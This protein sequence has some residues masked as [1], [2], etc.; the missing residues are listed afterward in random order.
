MTLGMKASGDEI[1]GPFTRS[2]NLPAGGGRAVGF[3]TSIRAQRSLSVGYVPVEITLAAQAPLPADRRLVYRFTTIEGGQT[4]PQNGMEID[5]P[6]LAPQ[7]TRNAKW[8]RYLPK[9]SAGFALEVT[10]YEDGRAILDYNDVLGDGLQPGRQKLRSQLDLEYGVNW[11]YVSPDDTVVEDKVPNLR[12][13]WQDAYRGRAAGAPSFWSQMLRGPTVLGVGQS[14]LPTDWRGYQNYDAVIL[15]T[16]SAERLVEKEDEWRA[17]RGWILNGGALVIYDAVSPQESSSLLGFAWSDDEESANRIVRGVENYEKG[18]S[19]RRYQAQRYITELQTDLTNT[20]SPQP[21]ANGGE[22][23]ALLPNNQ[24]KIDLETELKRWQERRQSLANETSFSTAEWRRR[25]HLQRVGSGEV[26]FLRRTAEGQAPP[27]AYWSVVRYVLDFRVSPTVRRGVDPMVG[28]RKFSSWL[29]PGVAQPPVYTFMG[30]LTAFVILVGPIAYRRTAKQG[31]SYLMFAIAPVLA[32]LT[33]VAMFG[34]GI[35]SDGFGTVV[36]VRQLT[37]VDGG[38]K[39]AGER[40]RSTYFAGVRPGNGLTFASDAEVVG[41]REGTGQAWE[42]LDEL[43]YA[44]MGRITIREDGQQFD[45]SFLPSRQQKQ[46]IT[47]RP[48]QDLGRVRLIPDRKGISS[49]RVKNEFPFVLRSLV[50]RDPKGAYWVCEEVSPGESKRCT[51]LTI[52]DTSKT[53]G[54]MYR[55]HQPVSAVRQTTSRVNQYRNLIFDVVTEINRNIVAKTNMSNGV[56]EHWLQSH[57][58][59]AGEIPISHFVGVSDVTEDVLA[60][61]NCEVSSSVRY[62]FGTLP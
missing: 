26:Y 18:L 12:G 22:M 55:D 1:L 58:Q 40:V 28:D 38:S 33:T 11:V 44:L 32:L 2:V 46:F 48:R 10:V 20:A 59:T 25:I 7:G 13:L 51:A 23:A 27:A 34:Y 5:V 24:P 36:R 39:A 37:W 43:S 29:I 19:T 15:S 35:V 54:K 6:I 50:V 41:Y 56:F 52:Q 57:L 42:E 62:V 60:V 8:V 9:W 16:L 45:S 3:R 31:R 14:E 30:L 47:H 61:E 49:P 17:L 21:N 53:L 4:P